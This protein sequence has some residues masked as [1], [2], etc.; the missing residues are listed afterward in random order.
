MHRWGVASALRNNVDILSE[1]SSAGA[2]EPDVVDLAMSSDAGEDETGGSF[3]GPAGRGFG[4]YGSASS[5]LSGANFR[6]RKR[7]RMEHLSAVD[8]FRDEREA[9]RAAVRELKAQLGEVRA[10]EDL[11]TKEVA[12]LT[13]ALSAATEKQKEYEEALVKM[14]EDEAGSLSDS[15]PVSASSGKSVAVAYAEVCVKLRS[16][17]RDMRGMRSEVF[18]EANPV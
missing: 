18:P 6:S 1:R 11:R 2:R 12:E 9:A 16:L 3:G 14:G 17:Q 8:T 7:T 15:D 4:G 10:R 13:A 5:S